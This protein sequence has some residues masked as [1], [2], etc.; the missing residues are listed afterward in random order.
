MKNLYVPRDFCLADFDH[1]FGKI[2]LSVSRRL[3][4]R[5]GTQVGPSRYV[6]WSA[7]AEGLQ[8]DH[9]FGSDLLRTD[10]QWSG[11]ATASVLEG[12]ARRTIPEHGGKSHGAGDRIGPRARCI[13]LN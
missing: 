12:G 10:F 3:R 7:K 4:I 1:H 5:W 2:R 13:F 11:V 9:T 6:R 8:G